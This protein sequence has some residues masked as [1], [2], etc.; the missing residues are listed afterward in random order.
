MPFSLGTKSER[1][2]I[3]QIRNHISLY[4][5]GVSASSC[6][7]LSVRHRIAHKFQASYHRVIYIHGSYQYTTLSISISPPRNRHMLAMPG[8]IQNRRYLCLPNYMSYYSDPCPRYVP[9]L[10]INYVGVANGDSRILT[11][12]SSR[13]RLI[14]Q[15]SY[16]ELF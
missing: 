12:L 10:S 9:I 2:V 1:A 14:H 16:S 15:P 8:F 4:P 11:I 5:A 7:T 3:F 6:G 13:L